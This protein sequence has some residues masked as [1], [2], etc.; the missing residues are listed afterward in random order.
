MTK[1]SNS[2]L[3]QYENCRYAY[4]LRYNLKVK[5]PY[6]TI[7]AF[8]G[9]AVHAALERLYTKLMDDVIVPLPDLIEYYNAVWDDRWHEHI[10]DPRGIGE[11]GMRD[12]GAE[13]ISNYYISNV[14]FDAN[15]T[16]GLE[17]DDELAL[18]NGDSFSV[19]IDRLA[20]RGDVVYVCDYKTGKMKTQQDVD[21]DRQLA[22][23]A[24]WVRQRYKGK[25]VVL[26][27]HM[28]RY[29]RD[30]ESTRTDSELDRLVGNVVDEIWEIEHCKDWKTN[31]SPL[32]AWCTY[33]HLCPEFNKDLHEDGEG[34][35]SSDCPTGDVPVYDCGTLPSK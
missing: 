1:Y 35:P 21:C 12:I 23:Y 28:L 19:R 31:P 11:D 4:N 32:C 13:C 2:R 16:I 9:T 27:W 34:L 14:P 5:T 7:E 8:M 18:P 24:K 10:I 25:K 29:D 20:F 17:T 6:E 33:R 30:M 22:M 3:T 15:I 26:R